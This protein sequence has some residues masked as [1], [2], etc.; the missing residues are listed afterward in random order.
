MKVVTS[1]KSDSEHC[2][3]SSFRFQNVRRAVSL[4][5][6]LQAQGLLGVLF[7]VLAGVAGSLLTAV[8]F[9]CNYLLIWT[10]TSM[11]GLAGIGTSLPFFLAN[12]MVL[13]FLLNPIMFVLEN[14]GLLY[15]RRD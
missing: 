6:F 3:F 14:R 10:F 1:V 15:S 2:G 12:N 7:G 8:N 5:T 13:G 11:I 4:Q 9:K